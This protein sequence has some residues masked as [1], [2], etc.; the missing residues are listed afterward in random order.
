[1]HLNSKGIE[2]QGHRGK[3]SLRPEN[4]IPSFEEAVKDGVDTIELDILTT[5]D[6]VLIIHHDFTLN[7]KLCT[8]LDG[9]S[10][11]EKVLIKD[12]SLSEI[13]NLD[14][15]SKTNPKF[16]QQTS[17]PGT[18]IPTLQELFDFI[19]KSPLP[20]AQKVHLNI[21]IKSNPN[22]PNLTIKPEDLAKKALNIVKENN[23]SDRIYFSSFDPFVLYWIKKTNPKAKV[24][25]IFD[26]PLTKNIEHLISTL[27]VDVLSPEHLLLTSK[28]DVLKL[29]KYG[30]RVITWTVNDPKRWEELI[31]RGVDGIVTD[32]PHELIKFLKKAT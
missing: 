24:G 30:A 28:E 11:S 15:G 20:H 23:F 5:S 27:K 13:K 26:K 2:I 18:K 14:C 31:E 4:T 32:Y 3:R 8:Y 21:E 12:L 29:K 7:P 22:S 9:G 19:K 10:I 16:P 6:G 25:F 17:I 1:M